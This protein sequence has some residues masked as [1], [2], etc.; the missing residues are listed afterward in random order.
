VNAMQTREDRIIEAAR[1]EA[2]AQY[3]NAREVL[4]EIHAL[5]LL[6]RAVLVARSAVRRQLTKGELV[7]P[8]ARSEA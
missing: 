6:R 5:T 1:H 8:D 4:V 3:P 2:R 7:E